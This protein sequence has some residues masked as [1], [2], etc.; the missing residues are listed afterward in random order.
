MILFVKTDGTTYR[1]KELDIWGKKKKKKQIVCLQRTFLNIILIVCKI[2]NVD[3][4]HPVCEN[5]NTININIL[6][7]AILPA[8]LVH[9]L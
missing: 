7:L 1:R 9:C 6:Q 2:Y 3:I 5:A 8:V 4:L